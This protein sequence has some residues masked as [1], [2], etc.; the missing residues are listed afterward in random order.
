M[1]KER[2]VDAKVTC[3]FL[4]MVNE[5]HSSFIKDWKHISIYKLLMVKSV[6]QW[7][8]GIKCKLNVLHTEE[9]NIKTCAGLQCLK[10]SK[11]SK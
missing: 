3:L 4:Y 11:T 6:L 5:M 2:R 1:E 10:N 7:Q 9:K 8:N